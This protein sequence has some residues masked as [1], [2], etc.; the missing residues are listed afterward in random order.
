MEP[1]TRPSSQTNSTGYDDPIVA[2]QAK[3]M[4]KAIFQH[5]SGTDYNATGDNGTSHGAGQWQ[6]ATW[7]AQ[8]KDVLGDENAPMTPGN[9]SI[10]AQG[11]IRKYI[12]QG[13]NAAQIAAIWNSGS[14][15]NWDTKIGVHTYPDGKQVPY[16]V[17]KYVKNVTDLYQ[18]YKSQSPAPTTDTNTQTKSPSL[19]DN[20]I[21]G[22]KAVTNFLAPI[23]PDIYHDIKGDNKKTVLQQAGDVGS[24]ALSAASLVPGI[25]P[26]A[27]VAKAGLAGKAAVAGKIG[28][29]AALGAGFGAT[30]ALGAGETDPNKITQSAVTGGMVGGGLGVAGHVA[31]GMLGNAAAKTGTSQLESHVN[32]SKPLQKVVADNSTAA[33]TPL[34]TFEEKGYTPQ[35]TVKDGRVDASAITNQNGTG[36][37]DNEL[38]NTSQQASNLV[39]SLKGPGVPTQEMKSEILKAVAENPAIRDAGKVQQA[40]NE[41]NNRFASFEKSF[42][43]YIPWVNVDSIRT[44]MNKEYDPALRD[45]ARTIGDKTRE[46]LYNGDAT[47]V[48]L[49]TAMQNESELI[50]AQNFAEKL[51]GTTVKGGRLGKHFAGLT[52]AVLGGAGFVGGGPLSSLI[53][54]Y[55]GKK[56]A[57]AIEEQAQKSYFN[58]TT[59]KIAQKVKGMIG[60]PTGQAAKNLAKVGLLK[61][62]Q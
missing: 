24:T 29:N 59:A 18:Q 20:V 61:Q 42:G 6:D 28:A 44:Q 14:D 26:E 23:I 51:Q 49:K 12:A 32:A 11:T 27:L 40:Q 22:A 1:S 57:E 60:S 62:S 13:K 15:E 45:V 19:V 10:V 31:G 5:E 36:S 38:E 52:G 21:G 17:P 33:T 7:K 55:A 8:A 2:Q 16:N 41:V 54:G 53:T 48:A 35:L 9:Q 4:T 47:N 30:N 3:N 39:K 58:P 46:F 37:L 25:G 50:K 34:K 56:A 43:D